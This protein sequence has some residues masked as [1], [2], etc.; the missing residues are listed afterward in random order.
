V[1]VRAEVHQEYPEL[2]ARSAE[3]AARLETE[4]M[5][6]LNASVDAEG[7]FPED[8]LWTEGFLG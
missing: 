6:D 7:E 1:T 5:Q 3:F 2:G 8:F 4:T